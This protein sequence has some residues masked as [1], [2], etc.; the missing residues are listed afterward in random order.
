MASDNR[1]ESQPGHTSLVKSVCVS[2]GWDPRHR[3]GGRC[4][5]TLCTAYCNNIVF[6]KH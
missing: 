6:L 5:Q 4:Q 2:G 3:G 1:L